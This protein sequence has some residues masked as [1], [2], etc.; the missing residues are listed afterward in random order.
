VSGRRWFR[1]TDL[2]CV[3]RGRIDHGTVR[4]P[5]KCPEVRP[6]RQSSRSGGFAD[7][8]A[9]FNAVESLAALIR[10]GWRPAAHASHRL[11]P[12]QAAVARVSRPR[13]SD[14]AIRCS[15]GRCR[16]VSSSLGRALQMP[17]RDHQ[18][19]DGQRRSW[20]FAPIAL[21]VASTPSGMPFGRATITT[22]TWLRST[23]RRISPEQIST[24]AR[25]R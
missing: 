20:K 11:G 6:G 14:P 22:S 17:R 1:T 19:G 15:R 12:S 16:S 21:P 24:P 25:I 5:W 3:K 2:S 23:R 8:S 13:R 7:S 10:S 4:T 18:S 9:E